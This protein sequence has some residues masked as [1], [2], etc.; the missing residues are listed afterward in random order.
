M[1]ICAGAIV[2]TARG[3]MQLEGRNGCHPWMWLASLIVDG[4]VRKNY[5][6]IITNKDILAIKTQDG[7]QGI[8]PGVLPK[9]KPF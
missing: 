1:K 4:K 5:V 9:E 2:L 3:A 6:R 7:F 8:L